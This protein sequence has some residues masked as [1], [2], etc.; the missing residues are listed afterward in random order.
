MV[1]PRLGEPGC[2]QATKKWRETIAKKYGGVKGAH[3]AMAANGRLGGQK[4]GVQ[5]GFAVSGKASEAG[6]KGGKTSKRG[7]KLLRLI[8][9]EGNNYT[10]Q[11][12]VGL[13]ELMFVTADN[14]TN[15]YAKALNLFHKLTNKQYKN[16]RK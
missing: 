13:D 10:Y 2:E 8:D 5:K 16:R 1:R 15:A 3:E 9:R 12:L 6:K 11:P 4:K 7:P 14:R